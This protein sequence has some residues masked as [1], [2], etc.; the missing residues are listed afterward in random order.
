VNLLRVL[1]L[2]GRRETQQTTQQEVQMAEE[3]TV[4]VMTVMEVDQYMGWEGALLP[5]RI[6]ASMEAAKAAAIVEANG[7][8]SEDNQIQSPD[9]IRW[10][11]NED[12]SIETSDEE[13]IV[14]IRISPV[15]VES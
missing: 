9:D 11:S 15:V 6:F 3:M 10:Y 8:L 4:F 12:G 5:G 14:V 7:E 1:F 2:K 13:T